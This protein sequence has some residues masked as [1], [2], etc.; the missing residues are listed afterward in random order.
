MSKVAII[1]LHF[2]D[3]KN[4]IECLDS[5]KKLNY[6]HKKI[7]TIVVDNSKKN[8]GFAGGINKGL[9]IGL[10]DKSINF[11]LVLNND[12]I[13]DQNLLTSFFSQIKKDSA[14]I[15]GCIIS[16]FLEPKKIWFAG[17]YLNKTFCFTK[18]PYL[19]KPLTS[20]IQLPKSDFI[21]GACMFMRREV[22]EKIGLFDENYFLYWEDVDFC[23]RAVKAKFKILCLDQPLVYHKVS[24]SAGTEGSNK[25]SNLRAY[26]Y[27]R[28]A[29]IFMKK[30]NLPM[31][32][33][34]FG[35]FFIRL[36]YYLSTVVSLESAKQ[37]LKGVK[38]GTKYYFSS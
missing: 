23:Y 38:D 5:L 15:L 36:P 6:D 14:D 25:L 28:N 10:K 21:T 17:G 11:F 4:T 7:K 30:H 31:L 18:H 33:G 19:N 32:T 22:L 1:V 26:Y 12:T 29:F 24:S 27:A 37:Y 34:I 35:Q 20:N 9:K 3:K 16:Y 8:L 2:G 13:V